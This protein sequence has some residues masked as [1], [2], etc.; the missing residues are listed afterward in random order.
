MSGDEALHWARQLGIDRLDA[1]RLLAHHLQRPREWL[2]AHAQETVAAPVLQAFEGD[3]RR[4]ADGV[5]LAYLTGRREFM[6]LELHV[7]PDVLVPRPETETLAAWAIE[8]VTEMQRAAG[9]V[10]LVDLGTGSGALALAIAAAC[11][12]AEVTGVD[13]STRALEIA[14]GNAQRL[15]LDLRLLQGDWWHAV[16]GLHF[17]LAVSNP[18]YVAEGDAHLDGLRHE[19]REALVAG[20]DGLGALRPIIDGAAQHLRGWLMVEHGWNQAAAVQGLMRAA[21]FSGIETRADLA[22]HPRCTAGRVD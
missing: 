1:T 10:H 7:T 9:R 6:G 19:P 14:R 3:C 20:A 13:A 11:P 12:R 2:I 16:D 15:G 22:G 17:E 18:P 8:R 4:R 5:P 21:G